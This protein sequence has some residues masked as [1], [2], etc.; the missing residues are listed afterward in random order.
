MEK[1]LLRRVLVGDELDIVHHQNIDIP[2]F[3]AKIRPVLDVVLIILYGLDKLICERFACSIHYVQRGI[4]RK[5]FMTYGVHE[6]RLAEPDSAVNK[7]RVIRFCGLGGDGLCGG[8]REHIRFADNERIERILG[9][10]PESGSIEDRSFG[11]RGKGFALS[12]ID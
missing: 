12:L 2:V 8:E 4:I 7:E 9:V 3:I 6:V 5:N 11:A 10:M 1:L